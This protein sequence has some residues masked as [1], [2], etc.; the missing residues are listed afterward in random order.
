VA[1]LGLTRVTL[2]R[3][4]DRDELATRSGNRLVFSP[5]E[6]WGEPLVEGLPRVLAENLEANGVGVVTARA[7]YALV[8]DID[9]FERDGGGGVGLA[10]RW[11]LRAVGRDEVVR[12][13]TTRVDERAGT[14]DGEA[15]ARALSTC[16][17]RLGADVAAA[18]REAQARENS[19]TI[20]RASA[21]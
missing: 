13:G 16:L 4:L 21:R 6:R 8:V 11:T 5:H 20:E 19:A 3:Y 15:T 14:G 18:V 7:D 2:P 17:G 10:A 12:S 9:R 1:T